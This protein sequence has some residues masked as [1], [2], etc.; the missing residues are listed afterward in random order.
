[1]AEH[2]EHSAPARPGSCTELFVA[3]TRLALQ[4]FGGVLPVA[5]RE[6]V[7]RTRWLT[8][9][10]F[11]EL[12]SAGQV[13]PG[14]NIVNVALIAG[15]RWFGWRGAL[16]AAGGLLLIPA[17]I[18]LAAGALHRHWQHL[19]WVAGALRGMGAVAAGLVV[20]TGLKLARTLKTHPLGRWPALGLAGLTLALVGLWRWPL[21][22]VVLGLGGASMALVA[23]VLRRREAGR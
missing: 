7:E 10:E 2:P 19:P 8:P 1:M 9:A 22:G 3:F 20:A 17:L 11:A 14:P 18:V 21:A 16:S 15:D 12:L 6:L 23:A 4:G 5:H 13:L